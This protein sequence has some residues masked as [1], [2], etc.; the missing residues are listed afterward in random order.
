MEPKPV[1]DWLDELAKEALTEARA[2]N[3]MKANRL[4]TNPALNHF[5]NNVGFER[6]TMT[7]E[8][9]AA[10]YPAFFQ[11]AQRLHQEYEQSEAIASSVERMTTIE[12]KLDKLEGLV[13]Q[14]VEAKKPTKRKKDAEAIAET[15]EPDEEAE[16]E[17]GDEEAD[18]SEA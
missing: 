3:P 12:S 8:Q 17:A 4:G 11:E 6:K 7:R 9:W 16:D 1:L 5:F 10:Y 13:M 14:L 15:P 2:G 18:E